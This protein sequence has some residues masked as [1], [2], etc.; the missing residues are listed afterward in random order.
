MEYPIL[1]IHAGSQYNETDNPVPAPYMR[2]SFE[3]EKLPE[4]ATA[5]NYGS[6]LL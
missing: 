5:G 4:H 3:L 1:F 2:R 6:R